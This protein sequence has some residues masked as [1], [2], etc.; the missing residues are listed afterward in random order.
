LTQAEVNE[1]AAGRVE[2]PLQLDAARLAD[3]AS[4][5]AYVESGAR[6]LGGD[7]DCVR[8]LVIAV[9]EAAANVMRHGYRGQPGPLEIDVARDGDSIVVRMRDDAPHFDPTTRPAPDLTIPLE[10]RPTGGFGI[11]L[12]RTCADSV[13]HSAGPERGNELTVVKRATSSTATTPPSS[14]RTAVE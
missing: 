9:N 4:I 3:L 8:D 13:T 10:H 7:R 1:E 5:R 2:V 6:A 14:E 11:H 12:T